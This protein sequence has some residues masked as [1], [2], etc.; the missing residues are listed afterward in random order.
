MCKF[1]KHTM[2]NSSVKLQQNVENICK[3]LRDILM[4]LQ[5]HLAQLYL[6]WLTAHCLQVTFEMIQIFYCKALGNFLEFYN[7]YHQI[8]SSA[9]VWRKWD[10]FNV[11]CLV[12]SDAHLTS[13]TSTRR[14]EF[15][16]KS[17]VRVLK[18][19]LLACK[20]NISE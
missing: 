3:Y 14:R 1:C 12:P 20:K 9:Q 17:S 13:K 6:F 19:S 5:D 16:K 4:K 15:V 7:I 2:C 8:S 18:S 11:V 10:R